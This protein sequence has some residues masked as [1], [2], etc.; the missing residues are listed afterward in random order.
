MSITTRPYGTLPNGQQVVE[1]TMRNDS[2]AGVS[3]LDFGGTI[4]R[5]LVPDREGKLG[6]VSLGFE[7]VMPYFKG[8]C[9]SMGGIIGRYGNRIGGARFTLE[10]QEYLLGKNN[11]ENNLHGGPQGFNQ[12]MWQAK[13]EE[14]DGVCSLTLTLTS[15]DGDQGFPGTL[16]A[17]VI[18]TFDSENTLGITYHADT[19]KPTL[20]NL[21]NH[22]Y[23][24]LDGH[25]SG[26]VEE[27]E[28]QI[29]ADFINEVDSGLI[30]TGKM[31]LPEETVYG[32]AKPARLGD[33]L[34]KTSGDPAL[35]NAGGVDF[36]YC[37]GRDKETK[38]CARVYSPR[39]GREM[40]VETDQPGVQLY[41]G[42]YLNY[43]GKDGIHYRRFGGLCLE[44]Q[45]YPDSP[46]QAHFPTTVLRPQ[47]HYYTFTRYHFG[48]RV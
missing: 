21:T 16:T 37:M 7:D 18:Y 5:I 1:Y 8:E 9:G 35:N 6:D 28:L 36:N 13:A 41:T 19:D 44:T 25:E 46:H 38:V 47:E 40:T 2:G 34:A 27:L 14:K 23:F 20:C 31:L 22:A 26:T 11:G 33:V 29:F 3:I 24:N 39:T 10:G 4:T 48:I 32:F 30:P 43:V 45:H 17:T 15:P 42:Q 12:R